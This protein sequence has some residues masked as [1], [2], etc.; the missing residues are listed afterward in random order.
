M[1]F[2]EKIKPFFFVEHDDSSFSACLYVDEY[3]PEIFEPR[4]EDGFDASGYDWASLAKVFLIE[5]QP[6]LA[7]IIRFNPESSM[8]CAYS[9]NKSALQNFVLSFK[10][11]CENDELIQ[12]LLSRAELD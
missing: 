1:D 10:D 2:K 11:A 5:Q 4:M 12:D 7:D 6:E 9:S 8:F 3:K